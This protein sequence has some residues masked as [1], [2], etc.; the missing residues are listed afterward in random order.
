MKITKTQLK[1]IIKE[2]LENIQEVDIESMSEMEKIKGI[3]DA[4]VQV[5]I[6]FSPALVAGL[7][8]LLVQ[9]YGVS[10]KETMMALR[11]KL[12]NPKK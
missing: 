1:E 4:F 9:Q 12:R 7:V 3:L 5:G 11:G 8:V 10:M 2:E 6:N